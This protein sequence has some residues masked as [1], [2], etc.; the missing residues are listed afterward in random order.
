MKS[1]LKLANETRII[2]AVQVSAAGPRRAERGNETRDERR[3]Q[4]HAA[5]DD[6]R[7]RIRWRDREVRL[8]AGTS[9]V[10]LATVLVTCLV[11]ALRATRAG[12]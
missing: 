10:L 4:E 7:N 8:A 2:I 11:P 12:R 1:S 3:R 5:G 9:G 6:E